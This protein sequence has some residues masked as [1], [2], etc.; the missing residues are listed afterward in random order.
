M[1]KRIAVV[2]RD[3]QGEALRMAIGLTL[4]DDTVNVYVLNRKLAFTEKVAFDLETLRD[5]EVKLYS[6][7]ADET[8]AE[9]VATEDIALRLPSY[10]HVLAY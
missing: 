5:L 3:R 9:F 6:N 1:A 8:E 7:V 10:D 2:V 4:K